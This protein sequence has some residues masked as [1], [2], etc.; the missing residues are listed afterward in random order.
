MRQSLTILATCA[1]I[2]L[3]ALVPGSALASGD[4][5]ASRFPA[6][7]LIW[8]SP[9]DGLKSVTAISKDD[10]WAVGINSHA[11]GYILHWNGHRWRPRACPPWAS[12][13]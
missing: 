13:R 2:G 12:S 6:W 9:G 7:R 1:A 4:A 10:A 5:P 11:N 8:Q 3:T